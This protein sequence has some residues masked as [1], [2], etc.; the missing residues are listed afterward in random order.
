MSTVKIERHA[1]ERVAVITL[2]DQRENR[3]S[4]ELIGDL[5]RTLDELEQDDDVGA[6][7]FTGAEPK[8][9]CTGLHLEWMMQ[10]AGDPAAIGEYLLAVNGLFKRVTIYP[11]PTVGA[12]NGHTFAAGAFLA[13]HL[14]FR[15]MREDR[16]WV[17]LPEIDINIPLLPGMIAI[18]QAVMPPQGFRQLYYTGRRFDGPQ[19]MGLGFVDEV[20]SEQELLPRSVAFAAELA[21]KRTRTYAEMKRRIRGEIARILEEEDPPMFAATLALSVP[22]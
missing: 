16:G 8:F 11:K 12:L 6:L 13:A 1:P 3:L 22:S 5:Q 7:V 15:L 14:D 19:A 4:L 2:D 20:H 17:C 9:F 18:C 21:K 10:H